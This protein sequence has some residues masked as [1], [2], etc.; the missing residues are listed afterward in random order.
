MNLHQ[1]SG[2][3]GRV[4]ARLQRKAAVLDVEPWKFARAI[5]DDRHAQCF[6][7]FQRARKIQNG[8]SARADHR[9]RSARDFRQVRGNVEAQLRS[10]VHAAD[11]AG[12]EHANSGERCDQHRRGHRGGSGLARGPHRGEVGTA[13]FGDSIGRGKSCKLFGR[14]P[15]DETP[16]QHGNRRGYRAFFAYGRFHC[17]G[18]LQILRS[19]Q[20]VRDDGGFKCHDGAPRLQGGGHIVPNHKRDDQESL[21]DPSGLITKPGAERSSRQEL[22][23][24]C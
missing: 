24:A 3:A 11:P 18:C 23:R 10:A 14:K 16:F 17:A 20:A 1:P 2:F 22:S 5:A 7:H 12:R 9:Y 19:R 13:D 21:P 15:Y 8:F 6:Q 4:Y